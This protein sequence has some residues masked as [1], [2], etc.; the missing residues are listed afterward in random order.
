MPG[1]LGVQPGL[2]L[3]CYFNA[4]PCIP[5]ELMSGNS[6]Y[7]LLY[8]VA[9]NIC[10]MLSL[11]Q[12]ID[13]V[14]RRFNVSTSSRGE[15]AASKFTTPEIFHPSS[16]LTHNP[17]RD[18]T[19]GYPYCISQSHCTALSASSRLTDC[20]YTYSTIQTSLSPSI[21]TQFA[22]SPTFSSNEDE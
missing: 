9:L 18:L 5:R 15:E 1:A 4:S 22:T 12:W 17:T 11:H 3:G 8:D 20:H 6:Q 10:I 2:S 13:Q 7:P 19:I 21:A 16:F 14:A